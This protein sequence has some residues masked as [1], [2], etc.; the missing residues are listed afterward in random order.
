[1]KREKQYT[2][3][4]LKRQHPSTGDMVFRIFKQLESGTEARKMAKECAEKEPG[5]AF[6]A[7]SIWPAIMTREIK[8][9]VYVD[10]DDPEKILKSIP[11]DNDDAG[12]VEEDAGQDDSKTI[13]I[14][15]SPDQKPE[16]VKDKAPEPAVKTPEPKKI[17]AI[18][19]VKEH[20]ASEPAK[21][22]KT[23]KTEPVAKP[24]EKVA[25]K[26]EPKADPKA[27]KEEA[28][29]EALFKNGTAPAGFANEETDSDDKGS[30]IDP[31][32]GIPNLF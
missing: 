19:S 17:D 8:S 30:G 15:I 14:V 32:S 23:E 11:G 25:P 10:P 24:K 2:N 12:D 28:D 22:K 16:P 13:K 29:F 3:Y 31:G 7:A 1:M 9:F 27:S 18:P 6:V 20:K 4:V 26:P 5:V 21:E